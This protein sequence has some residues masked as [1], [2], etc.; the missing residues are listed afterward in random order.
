MCGVTASRGSGLGR[1]HV[2]LVANQGSGPIDGAGRQFE[3]A[4]G[5]KAE[6]AYA[7]G[8]DSAPYS[9][10]TIVVPDGDYVDREGHAPGVN[11]RGRFDKQTIGRRK[12]GPAK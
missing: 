3:N 8:A 2:Q 6:T 5:S 10:H 12:G 1:Q 7:P 4:A 11:A 9:N